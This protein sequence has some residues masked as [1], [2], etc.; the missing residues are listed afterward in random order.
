MIDL[1]MLWMEWL[2][3][4][5]FHIFPSNINRELL[6]VK[7]N[8]LFSAEFD[9]IIIWKWVFVIT[10]SQYTTNPHP[11]CPHASDSPS[12]AHPWAEFEYS[13]WSL[14]VEQDYLA[15]SNSFRWQEQ[16][17]CLELWQDSLIFVLQISDVFFLDFN[18]SIHKMIS[19]HW[20]PQNWAKWANYWSM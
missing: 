2:C 4:W 17:I 6:Q 15:L 14:F 7:Q 20:K 19:D 11:I 16:T 1:V 13:W 10:S 18:T 9:G 3:I 12:P 8:L 5:N